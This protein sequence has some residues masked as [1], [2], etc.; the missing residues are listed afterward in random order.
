M[1]TIFSIHLFIIYILLSSQF[2]CCGVYGYK[3]YNDTRTPLSRCHL[4]IVACAAERYKELPGC[5]EE[6]LNY[7]DT[8]LQI[9]L[10]SSLGIAAVQ[11]ACIVI[12]VLTVYK[13]FIK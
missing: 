5:R 12:G 3:D 13:L 4:E 7:W 1:L 11:V 10:Y 9:T 2:N 8:Y 6:F